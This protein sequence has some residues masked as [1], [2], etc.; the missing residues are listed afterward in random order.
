MTSGTALRMAVSLFLSTG[1]AAEAFQWSEAL[2]VVHAQ[3]SFG[4]PVSDRIETPFGTPPCV[5]LSSGIV[6]RTAITY[7]SFAEGYPQMEE[8]H[9]GETFYLHVTGLG[10]GTVSIGAFDD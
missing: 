10:I 9:A 2:M 1:G 6:A 4:P 8:A 3:S 5:L 7:G